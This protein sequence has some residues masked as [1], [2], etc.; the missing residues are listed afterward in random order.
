MSFDTKEIYKMT[1]GTA[2]KRSASGKPVEE[3]EWTYKMVYNSGIDA[4][5]EKQRDGEPWMALYLLPSQGKYFTVDLSSKAKRELEDKQGDLLTYDTLSTFMNK[6]SAGDVLHFKHD[7]FDELRSNKIWKEN[8]LEL[9][10]Q[11]YF[12]DYAKVGMATASAMRLNDRYSYYRPYLN[13]DEQPKPE[14]TSKLIKYLR[15][16]AER[17]GLSSQDISQLTSGDGY[18]EKYTKD[19]FNAFKCF[20]GLYGFDTTVKYFIEPY[21]QDEDLSNLKDVSRIFGVHGGMYMYNCNYNGDLEAA[22]HD[23]Y[24][25]F[26]AERLSNYLYRDSKKQGKSAD[27]YEFISTYGDTLSMQMDLFGKI[28]DKYPKY[29]ASYHDVLA[30]QV[31]IKKACYSETE[32]YAKRAAESL[33]YEGEYGGYMLVALPTVGDII[34]EAM[35]NQNCVRSYVSRVAKGE[36][37]IMS[38]RSKDDPETTICTTEIAAHEVVQFLGRYNRKATAIE[39]DAVLHIMLQYYERNKMT[40]LIEGTKKKLKELA[41]E[42]KKEKASKMNEKMTKRTVQAEL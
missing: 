10:S 4:G 9:L 15:L 12:T 29:L 14:V 36:D 31:R 7:V 27:L 35:Q 22:A 11:Q 41:P 39:W 21:V 25:V 23:G 42:V 2:V 37:Y 33:A 26:D 6:L 40:A 20:L 30:Y 5:F 32:K 19:T 13:W 1:L 3:H 17:L 8:F 28:R 16:N 18:R 38:F 34:N 24:R